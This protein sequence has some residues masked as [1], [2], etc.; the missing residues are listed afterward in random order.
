MFKVIFNTQ[1]H[2]ARDAEQ[3]GQ[4][5]ARAVQAGM[6]PKLRARINLTSDRDVTAEEQQECV[7]HAA[8]LLVVA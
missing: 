4:F 6:T 7:D 3:A 2:E 5:I 1:V 8:A